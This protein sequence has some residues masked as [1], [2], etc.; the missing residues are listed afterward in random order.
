MT[1]EDCIACNEM[2]GR[3]RD[4]DHARWVSLGSTQPSVLRET[5]NRRSGKSITKIR[6]NVSSCSTALPQRG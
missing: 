5:S 6:A 3:S 4:D 1:V 2:K